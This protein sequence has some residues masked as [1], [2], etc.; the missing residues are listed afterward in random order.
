MKRLL[1]AIALVAVV[2]GIYLFLSLS[3]D[4]FGN[5]PPVP[6]DTAP[7]VEATLEAT[8]PPI[9][10]TPGPT[11]YTSP[12]PA[13]VEVSPTP[14]TRFKGAFELPVQGATGF[15][16]IGL[17]LRSR[18]SADSALIRTVEPGAVFRILGVEGA[19]FH[20]EGDNFSG[21]LAHQ[22]CMINLPDIIP[23]IVYENTNASSSLLV[24]SGKRL[25]G[26][27]GQKLYD[28]MAYSE[29]FGRSEYIMPVL[30]LMAGKI[31][32]AQSAALRDGNSLKIYE[33]YRPHNVQRSVVRSMEQLS[34]ADETVKNGISGNGWKVSWFISQGI[35]NHQRGCAIDASLVRVDAVSSEIS[36]DYAY[37]NI[38]QYTEYE[39]PTAMHELSV[40]AA[41]FQYPVDSTSQTAWKNAGAAPA[42]NRPAMLL[43][44]YLTDAGLTP[45]AS[46]WWHFNDLKAYAA[47]RNSAGRGGF[48]IDE[49]R[50]VPPSA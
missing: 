13:P 11:P 20:V 24:S 15:A 18:A 29:R 33:A 46:E 1:G 12:S 36:G 32:A 34:S 40:A 6:Q 17:N 45:L 48:S 35:S 22:Y 8:A 5:P 26:I 44:R 4:H 38:T 2:V 42:M 10:E 50:S 30:Y 3:D 41:A 21:Y 16:S 9:R 47:I 14:A 28:A 49:A 25:P 37:E 27:T 43:Q 19:C 23:S 39:M 7:P 31:Q